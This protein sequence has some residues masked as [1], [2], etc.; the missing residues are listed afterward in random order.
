LL[1]RP[2]HAGVTKFD[3]SRSDAFGYTGH[4]FLGEVGGAQP[5]TGTETVPAGNRVTR[6]DMRT[7]EMVPF[8][9]AKESGLGPA[10]PFRHIVSAGPKRPVDVRFSPMERA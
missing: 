7:G 6:I 1:T 4:M 10:G 2:K 9:R 8:F 3:F 5:I